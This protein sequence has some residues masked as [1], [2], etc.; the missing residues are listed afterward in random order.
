MR[1]VSAVMRHETNT[2]SPIPTPW[3]AF[4]RESPTGEPLAGE[5]AVAVY[6]GTNTP[7]AAYIDLAAE[8]RAELELAIA[9]SAVP[10]A[11]ADDRVLDRCTEAILA[12]MGR[13]C[14]A[15]LLDLHGA[16]VTRG[17]ADA[18]GE[19][20]R[21]IREAAPAAPIAVA[22]DFHSNL[23]QTFIEHATVVAG[24]R[25]Y[26]HVD[27][28]ETGVR[29]GRTL[30]AALAG[31][32]DPVVAWRSLP[33]LSH[34][35]CQTPSRQPMKDVMDRAIAAEA[36]GT[37]LNASVFGGF[38]LADI[39]CVGMHVVVV[40]ERARH[41]AGQALVDELARLAWSRRADFVFRDEPIER[42]ISR[43]RRMRGGPIVLADHGDVAGSGG[44][45]DVM[46][47]LRE[48]MRQGLED[49]VAGPFADPAAV[50]RLIEAGVGAHCTLEVGGRVDVPAIGLEARPLEVTGTVR[51]ITDGRFRVMG[52]MKTGT[53]QFLGRCAVLDTGAVR[54]LLSERRHE[55]FDPGCFTQAGLDPA[56]ARYV[57]LKSRQHFRA[58]FEAIAKDVVMVSGPGVC[59]S[60]YSRFPWR[61]VRRPVYPLDPGVEA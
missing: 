27:M 18:E 43:A 2:F 37:V 7:V 50:A 46:E 36:A 4:G 30:L 9:A 42:S 29:A 57:L 13:G 35:N 5:K 56:A 23:S 53:R 38:P 12:A 6:R 8:A 20:L 3:E 1:F 52:P 25:T 33:M 34:L 21:R 59:T 60:D 51:A 54:M 16:M 39:P 40:A 24:Y 11:P 55:P 47:V 14:D 41:G 44:S 22:L 17:H 58:G 49:V 10:S 26:P 45:T 61:E 48:A 28:Y 32:C 31:E 15:L 19:L